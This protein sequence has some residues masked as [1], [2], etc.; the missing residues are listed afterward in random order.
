MIWT[1]YS[2]NGYLHAREAENVSCSAQEA[3]CLTNFNLELLEILLELLL[4]T[5]RLEKLGPA[6]E[7]QQ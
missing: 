4:Y 7:L 6:E 3:G 5:G 1:E 2:N